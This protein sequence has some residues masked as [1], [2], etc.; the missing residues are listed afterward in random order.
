M[1][2]VLRL[3]HVFF[4][5]FQP[6]SGNV[7]GYDKW[8][9]LYPL[10]SSHRQFS[11]PTSGTDFITDYSSMYWCRHVHVA[12]YISVSNIYPESFVVICCTKYSNIC[13]L[14]CKTDV[15]F[16]Y[17][18]FLSLYTTEIRAISSVLQDI[19]FTDDSSESNEYFRMFGLTI[20]II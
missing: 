7:K 2:V 20:I 9:T 4:N 19:S 15:I 13:S 10:L 1:C 18:L 17:C 5:S 6:L 3:Q 12:Q 11:L 14:C 8:G 16:F